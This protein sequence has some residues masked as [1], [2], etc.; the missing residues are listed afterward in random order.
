MLEGEEVHVLKEC[1]PVQSIGKTVMDKGYMFVWDPREQVPYMIPPS[2]VNQCDINVP[3]EHRICATRVVEYVP[4]YDEEVHPAQFVPPDC[5]QNIEAITAA[6][7]GTTSVETAD[8]HAVSAGDVFCETKPV[9]AEDIVSSSQLSE[10]AAAGAEEAALP[11]APSHLGDD[12]ALLGLVAPDMEDSDCETRKAALEK[13]HTIT[14]FPANPFC[15]VCRIAET[16]SMKDALKPDNKSDSSFEQLFPVDNVMTKSWDSVGIGSGGVQLLHMNCNTC[17]GIRIASPMTKQETS[18]TV[19]NVEHSNQIQLGSPY[20]YHYVHSSPQA[21]STES[22]AQSITCGSSKIFWKTIGCKPFAG[23]L[24]CVGQLNIDEG[25]CVSKETP[26]PKFVPGLFLAVARKSHLEGDSLEVIVDMTHLCLPEHTTRG[27]PFPP[28]GI[29]AVPPTSKAVCIAC[30]RLVKLAETSSWSVSLVPPSMFVAEDITVGSPPTCDIKNIIDE[31]EGSSVVEGPTE[32]I[33]VGMAMSLC[34]TYKAVIKLSKHKWERAEAPVLEFEKW[35]RTHST[36]EHVPAAND[37]YARTAFSIETM[38][39]DR[40]RRL[41]PECIYSKS[42]LCMPPEVSA[43][44]RRGEQWQK[45]SELH[46]ASIFAGLDAIV[47]I[48]EVDTKAQDLFGHLLTLESLPRDIF[49][50]PKLS[51]IVTNA[52]TTK[53][54]FRVEITNNL[55]ALKD[56][57]T[58]AEV[59]T[60]VEARK[61]NYVHAPKNGKVESR[62]REV[63]VHHCKTQAIVSMSF[64]KVDKHLQ[65]VKGYVICYVHCTWTKFPPQLRWNPWI[66]ETLQHAVSVVRVKHEL[67]DARCF[68]VDLMMADLAEQHVAF[69][70]RLT[71][72]WTRCYNDFQSCITRVSKR[73]DHLR[74][75]SKEMS[76]KWLR[77]SEESLLWSSDRAAHPVA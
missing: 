42:V 60:K 17:Y 4:Q 47:L 12:K 11:S 27:L 65:N 63:S 20:K 2:L 28:E 35:Q 66:S 64:Y 38:T 6:P 10:S 46:H 58:E 21:C 1:P 75:N 71:Q 50:I 3:R 56:V 76:K 54:L 72:N 45:E 26:E 52:L 30:D 22:F 5:V 69:L 40:H 48:V 51:F 37:E 73:H 31:V 70:E 55:V 32:P 53:S 7:A 77:Q 67:S 62:A 74:L 25:K 39:E 57:E 29:K 33:N 14:R 34:V 24:N 9:H 16:S 49:N 61:L 43:C 8:H 44:L 23:I 15:L 19:E 36:N 68:W 41:C 18:L 13:P 59:L